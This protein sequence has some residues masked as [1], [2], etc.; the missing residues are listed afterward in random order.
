MVGHT[1]SFFWLFFEKKKMDEGDGILA[2]NYRD[3][4][5]SIHDGEYASY[6]DG[7]N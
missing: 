3:N 5:H 2:R 4:L 1:L 7:R 6:F